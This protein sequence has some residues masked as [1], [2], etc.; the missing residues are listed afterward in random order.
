[1]EILNKMHYLM[2]K[3][4]SMFIKQHPCCQSLSELTSEW[5]FYN[6]TAPKSQ[7]TPL[8]A[9]YYRINAVNYMNF[10]LIPAKW[11]ISRY[12]YYLWEQMRRGS[13]NWWEDIGLKWIVFAL[14]FYILAENA[15]LCH[16]WDWGYFKDM[17]V[18][19]SKLTDN[20]TKMPGGFHI[21]ISIKINCY[22][23]I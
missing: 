21:N 16:L 15:S 6:L 11:V 2:N 3:I 19:I 8:C 17:L 23:Y 13:E 20:V 7:L 10:A 18:T 14:I 5:H 4:I 9:P 12:A 1:M 22:M